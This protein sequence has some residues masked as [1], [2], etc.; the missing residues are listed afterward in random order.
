MHTLWYREHNRIVKALA[1]LNPHWDDEKLFQETRRIVVAEMQKITYSEWLS[2]VLGKSVQEKVLSA[3]TYSKRADASIS[4]AF[5]TA[6]MRSIKSLSDGMPKLYDENRVANESIFM[7]NYFHNPGLL[8]H[9]GV[10][11]ALARG[12]ATQPSQRLD[13]YYADDVSI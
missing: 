7:R 12:L 2:A 3:S 8:R 11:D 5:A 13:I 4:N 1:R 6:V 9:K 10:L